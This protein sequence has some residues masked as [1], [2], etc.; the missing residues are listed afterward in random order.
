MTTSTSSL[1]LTWGVS[2]TRLLAFALAFGVIAFV[3]FGLARLEPARQSTRGFLGRLIGGT[4]GRASTSKFQA[5]VWTLITLFGFVEVFCEHVLLGD[6]GYVSEIPA[7]LFAAMGFSMTTMIAAK[8]ITVSYLNQGRVN[9]QTSAPTVM[10]NLVGKPPAKPGA[11]PKLGGLGTNDVGEPDLSKIQMLAFTL[12]AVAVYLTR[13]AVQEHSSPQLPELDPTLMVLMGLS[14][15][16]YLGKKLT[17]TETPRISGISP[18]TGKADDL[19]VLSGISFGDT[20]AGGLV[21]VDGAPA[22]KYDAWS[23]TRLSFA[24]PPE[25]V[26]GVPWR[27]GDRATVTLLVN[28]HAATAPIQFTLRT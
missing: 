1:A 23:D 13:L 11:T 20:Q 2:G 7:N 6:P 26:P 18:G 8:G 14:Q 25:R 10:P 27:D 28:G 22:T 19:V 4:D 3:L 16:A 17:T 24:I 12:I 5:L 21:L 15:G 9:Q